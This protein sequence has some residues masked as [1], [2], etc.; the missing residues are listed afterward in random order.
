V[1]SALLCVAAYDFFLVPPLHTFA[2]DDTQYLFTFAV[3]LAAGLMVSTL[4]AQL[5]ERVEDARRRER[6][7]AA[8]YALSRDLAQATTERSM[9]EA[10]VGRARATFGGEAVIFLPDER[11]RIT[12]RTE[13][14]HRVRGGRTE[15][16]VAQ[17]TFERVT[18]EGSSV[19]SAIGIYRALETP[20]KVLGVLGIYP[21]DPRGFNSTEI[22][23]FSRHVRPRARAFDRAP[24]ALGGRRG[25]AFGLRA[26]AHA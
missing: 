9:L 26:G 25:C 4:T 2:V 1:W 10:A 20:G 18:K 23:P 19:S 14:W 6:H 24:P 22:A 5:R 3:M 21:I 15:L 12:P 7:T 13:S 11:G 16:A 17:A 8:L